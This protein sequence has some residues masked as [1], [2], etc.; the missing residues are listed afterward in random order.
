MPFTPQQSAALTDALEYVESW[1][2]YRASRERVP[3]VQ[4]A[5]WFDGG[6]QLS[7]VH[8]FADL[9]NGVALT[10]GHL[11]R[12]AS[13]SK[14]FTSTAIL[15][16]VEQ[17]RLRLDD[18]AGQYLPA[19]RDAKSRIA[20]ATVRELLEHSAGVIR[21]GLDGDYWQRYRPFPDTDELVS[22]LLDQGDKF[23]P[24]ESFNYSNVGYSL[25]GL[26]VEAVTGRSYN[27]HVVDAVVRPLG[28]TNTGP[29]W[30]EA[31]SSEYALGYS[32]L[33]QGQERRILDHVD[34]RAMASA[35]GFY[36]TA[37]DL[38][39]YA[40]AHFDGDER[41]LGEHS[42]R[43]AQKEAWKADPEN[44]ATASYG[45]GFMVANVGGHRVVGHSGGYPGHITRTFFDPKTGLAVS[46]L[47]N[48]ID[49]PA[50]PLANGILRVLDAALEA[51]PTGL[52]ATS[53]VGA[54][55]DPH[56]FTGRFANEWGVV[57]IA[58]LG[59]RLLAL[60]PRAVDPLDS[61]DT[62]T[63]VS[64]TELLIARGSGFGAVGERMRYEFG[65]DG[66]VVSLRGAGGMTF[67]PFVLPA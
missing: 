11:F 42:R 39:T 10:P 58:V 19:L 32:G 25:L 35:T 22:M 53:A 12:I 15:Q 16:L 7:S 26:I 18:P 17:G 38:V 28:L 51:A 61:F 1:L 60:D 52:A 4:A 41:L 64:A 5:V 46:V 36:G 37:V 31:R 8:G 21:D 45:L 49:G 54:G 55:V 50:T 59:D 13:H 44:P 27:E 3:G 23:A 33:H 24:G 43:L 20:D 29:E 40:S 66:R 6:V 48:A 30:D 67:A 56:R 65:P 47:T 2:A 62:L 34:T 57:D 14:T 63:I 9:E